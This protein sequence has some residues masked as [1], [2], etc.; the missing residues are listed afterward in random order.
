[1]NRKNRKLRRLNELHPDVRV[2]LINRRDFANLLFKYGL[3]DEQEQL[4]GQSAIDSV[5][6][7]SE[8]NG[9]DGE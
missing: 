6:R 1:M 7:E 8:T 4:V 9:G 2:K 5:G 3:E